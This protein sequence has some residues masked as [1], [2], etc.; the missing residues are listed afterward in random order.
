MSAT[1]L[2]MLQTVIGL[3]IVAM[4]ATCTLLMT[5]WGKKAGVP[6]PAMPLDPGQSTS[7]GGST[8][9]AA[10]HQTQV[11]T[12]LVQQQPAFEYSCNLSNLAVLGK[13][14]DNCATLEAVKLA[15]EE[16]IYVSVKTASKNH[17]ARMLPVLLTWLQTVKPQQVMIE[18]FQK[19][20]ILNCYLI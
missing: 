1:L 10:T 6:N 3:L 15:E 2:R 7:S 19:I 18:V 4:I 20:A 12:Q 11:Q 5:L 13:P 17:V 16:D 14:L 8:T 9:A